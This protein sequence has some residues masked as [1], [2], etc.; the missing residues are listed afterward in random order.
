M[1]S[2]HQSFLVDFLLIVAIAAENNVAEVLNAR[3]IFKEVADSQVDEVSQ[4]RVHGDSP[5]NR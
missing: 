4:K 2:R 5:K 1:N 3:G